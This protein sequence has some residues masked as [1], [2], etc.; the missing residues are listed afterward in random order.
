MVKPSALRAK[1]SQAKTHIEGL[2]HFLDELPKI[3]IKDFGT[4]SLKAE[5]LSLK[6][7]KLEQLIEEIFIEASEATKNSG[8]SQQNNA[9]K[10]RN[11]N[12]NQANTSEM[13][14][15]FQQNEFKLNDIKF[16][17]KC[18]ARIERLET[19]NSKLKRT[20]RLKDVGME[21]RYEASKMSRGNH[22]F[23]MEKEIETLKLEKEG[24]RL[25]LSRLEG[26]LKLKQNRSKSGQN[27]RRGDREKSNYLKRNHL[28]RFVSFS[29]SPKKKTINKLD[30]KFLNTMHKQGKEAPTFRRD[31]APGLIKGVI[32]SSRRRRKSSDRPD[33]GRV[34][35]VDYDSL[36][37][38]GVEKGGLS[39]I[40]EEDLYGDRAN[41]YNGT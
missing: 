15:S 12:P 20:L 7:P 39:E 32:P 9:N 21:D 40:M 34:N 30:L 35:F 36:V 3:Q 24:L 1:F 2:R 8:K 27:T 23:T 38:F 31:Q 29:A 28:K 4:I 19:Q 6:L 26:D 11:G 17:Q 41:V 33:S 25:K 14:G 13:S 5:N 22:F 37:N 10:G 16:L 18:L